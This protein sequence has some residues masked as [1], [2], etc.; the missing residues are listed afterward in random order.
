VAHRHLP[1][2]L[3][4][5]R[6]LVL[7]DVCAGELARQPF[8]RAHHLERVHDLVATQFRDLRAAVR[9]QDD[10]PFRRQHLERLAQRRARDGE[11]FAQHA[12]VE[13]FAGRQCAL[14]DHVAQLRDDGGVQHLPADRARPGGFA[15]ASF[16]DGNHG[17]AS[18]VGMA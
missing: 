1:L 13:P 6:Q 11:L 10:Q 14:G 16:T 2:Q 18:R 3:A 17:L 12:F 7:G 5:L 15:D 9:Q 4:D 8:Q